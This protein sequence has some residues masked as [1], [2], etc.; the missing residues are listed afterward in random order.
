MK[1]EFVTFHVYS[2]GVTPQKKK[3]KVFFC[4]SAIKNIKKA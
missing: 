3:K 4:A 2:A 1:G